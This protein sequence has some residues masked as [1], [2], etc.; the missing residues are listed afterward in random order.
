MQIREE[1]SK[2]QSKCDQ[3]EIELQKYKN[4]VEQLQQ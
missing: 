1:Y 4:Y 3:L 2:L